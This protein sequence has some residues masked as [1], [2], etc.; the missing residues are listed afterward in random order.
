MSESDSSDAPP[1]ASK[2]FEARH[3]ANEAAKATTI[4]ARTTRT[5]KPG[6]RKPAAKRLRRRKSSDDEFVPDQNDADDDDS[7]SDDAE[8]PPR[9]ARP[10]RAAR[11]AT[12]GSGSKRREDMINRR[13]RGMLWHK[14]EAKIAFIS[15]NPKRPAVS[16]LSLIHISEPTRPY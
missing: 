2:E 13:V 5:K 8:E 16:S 14:P 4:R 6:A 1:L 9:A 3:R 10:K 15:P 11:P 7:D 12:R